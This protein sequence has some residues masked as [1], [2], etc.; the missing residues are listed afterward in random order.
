MELVKLKSGSILEEKEGYSRI[1][2]LDNWI[3][4]SLTAGRDYKTRVM[5]ETVVEQARQAMKNVEGALE[6]GRQQP[7][8]CCAATHLH[9]APGRRPGSHGL[10][11]REVPGHLSGKLRQL[12]SVGRT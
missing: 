2:A 6:A 4:M 7:C 12:W 9:S 10:Y 5:P 11:G 3:F 1:V 8:G